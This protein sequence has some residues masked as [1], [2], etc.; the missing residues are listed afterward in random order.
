LVLGAAAVAAPRSIFAQTP[1]A[2][3]EA[4]AFP[5]GPLGEQAQW[6]LEVANAGPGA[7]KAGE[8]ESHFH[9]SFF[10]ET[11]MTEIFKTLADLQ[12]A[13]ITYEIDF[14]T[15]I[16]TMDLPATNGRFIMNGSDGSQ[17]EV[18]IQID[19]ETGQIVGLSIGPVG[20]SATPEASP[21]S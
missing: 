8:I 9:I 7:I 11:S 21:V 20:G 2:S 6:I 18:S 3:P 17:T 4:A 1:A 12:S 10:E 14:N 16:T 5:D 15:F 19:R 13:G